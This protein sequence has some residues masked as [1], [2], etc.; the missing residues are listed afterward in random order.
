MHAICMKNNHA[1]ASGKDWE[2]WLSGNCLE[3]RCRLKQL[4]SSQISRSLLEARV[5]LFQF[6]TGFNFFLN[7]TDEE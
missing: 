6:Y 3:P 2:I 4:S 1:L 7:I 5:R